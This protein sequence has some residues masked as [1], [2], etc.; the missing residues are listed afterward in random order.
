MPYTGTDQAKPRARSS[1]DTGAKTRS[2]PTGTGQ[3][4]IQVA[5]AS[6]QAACA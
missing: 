4:R 5:H 2:V 6:V 3:N 1:N